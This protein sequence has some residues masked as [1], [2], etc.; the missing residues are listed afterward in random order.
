VQATAVVPPRCTSRI[1][2][3]DVPLLTELSDDLPQLELQIQPIDS[4]LRETGFAAVWLVKPMLLP[5]QSPAR[6][7]S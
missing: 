4:I 6:K 1:S 5:T 2:V 3:G 7:R